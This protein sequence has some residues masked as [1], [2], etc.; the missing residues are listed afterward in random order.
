[1]GKKN[2]AYIRINRQLSSPERSRTAVSGSRAQKDCHYPTGLYYYLWKSSYIK[3]SVDG[4]IFIIISR[5]TTSLLY[6]KINTVN[7]LNYLHP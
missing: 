2:V 3:S 1:M 4:K 6:I 7:P 5:A